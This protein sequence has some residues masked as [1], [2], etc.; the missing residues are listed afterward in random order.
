MRTIESMK[1]EKQKISQNIERLRN[2]ER[3]LEKNIEQASMREVW[4]ESLKHGVTSASELR[5][6]F[7]KANKENKIILNG[8]NNNGI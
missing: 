7:A 2:R 8:G 4:E 6:L 3:E 1:S 5:E